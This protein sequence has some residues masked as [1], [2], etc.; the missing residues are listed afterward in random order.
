MNFLKQSAISLFA[1]SALFGASGGMLGSP[2]NPAYYTAN[3][4]LIIQNSPS[5]VLPDDVYGGAAMHTQ[6][7]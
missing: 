3:N 2:A 5:S 7:R 1:C 6:G 4:T